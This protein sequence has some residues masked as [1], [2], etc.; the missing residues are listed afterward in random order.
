[1]RF[2]HVIIDNKSALCGWMV[3]P[4]KESNFSNKVERNCTDDIVSR[5]LNDLEKGENDPICQP[6]CVVILACGLDSFD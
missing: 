4:D 2:D 5:T 6:E 3:G 1:M